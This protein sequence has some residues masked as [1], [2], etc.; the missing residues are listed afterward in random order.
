M[1]RCLGIVC[2]IVLSAAAAW[3]E[4]PAATGWKKAADLGIN[5][6]QSAYSNSWAGQENAAIHWTWVA[7]LDAERQLSPSFNWRNALKLS[8][9]QTHREARTVGDDG[10]VERAWE[11]PEKSTD[12]IFFET[13]LR[14]TLGYLVDPFAGVTFESQFYDPADSLVAGGPDVRVTRAVHPI[15]LTE[16]AGVGRTLVKDDRAELYSRLGFALRQRLQRD[17]VSFEPK[18]FSSRT[19]T[20]GGLEWVT[21][22]AQTFGGG[23]LKY[24]SKLRVFQAFFH[25]QKDE[26]RGLPEEDYWRTPDVAWENTLS[27][28]VAKYVQVSLFL[29]LLYDKEIDLRGRFREILG[30]GLAYKLF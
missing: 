15:L 4:E 9:G 27:A 10:R 7:N 12:R 21:D 26:L 23:G 3:A 19:T 5:F 20:D 28:S 30:L 17:V 8:F 25:S 1:R 14:A 29:E 16:S 6:N 2:L 22:Y 13:L 24:I 11:S 18:A